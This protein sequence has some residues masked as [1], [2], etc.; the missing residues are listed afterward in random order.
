M[1]WLS[2]WW[3]HKL[4]QNSRVHTKWC[5]KQKASSERQACRW[6]WVRGERPWWEEKCLR[7]P[8]AS[9][10][11]DHN[12]KTPHWVCLLSTKIWN[13][14]LLDDH[15]TGLF[16]H[17]IAASMITHHFTKLKS[18]QRDSELLESIPAWNDT[19]IRWPDLKSCYQ[20]QYPIFCS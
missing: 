14:R 18:S 13:R 12:S 19:H 15:F 10:W 5:E 7:T 4:I 9:R 1:S 3:L 6:E 11:R 17:L 16:Y 8:Q 2:V 20:S